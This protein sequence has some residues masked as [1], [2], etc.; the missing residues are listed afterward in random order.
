[1]KAFSSSTAAEL[2]AL[3]GDSSQSLE[4]IDRLDTYVYFSLKDLN[5]IPSSR[6][7]PAE[8]KAKLLDLK[9]RTEQLKSH[10]EK[11]AIE[12][13]ESYEDN[14]I[15]QKDIHTGMLLWGTWIANEDGTGAFAGSE[16]IKKV[17]D[18]LEML[19]RICDGAADSVEVKRGDI[20]WQEK[21]QQSLERWAVFEYRA[22]FGCYPS[23]TRNGV[24]CKVMEI[25]YREAR[26]PTSNAFQRVVKAI[27]RDQKATGF[28]SAQIAQLKPI[29]NIHKDRK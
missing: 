23:K 29:R 6:L 16:S 4:Y 18:S 3:L 27:D 10:L 17:K 2:L 19:I 8:I 20:S 14:E 25:I 26:M 7:S 5:L 28:D 12:E 13:G 11:V 21:R 24:F 9:R 22:N 15:I 1:M